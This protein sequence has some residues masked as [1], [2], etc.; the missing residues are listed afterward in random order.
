MDEPR[1]L[2]DDEQQVWRRL[3]GVVLTLPAALEQ[4][5]QR[6]AGI[7]H[8]EYWVMA[9]LS[10]APE[11]RMKLSQ[12]AAMANASLSRLS[13]VMTRLQRRGWVSRAPCPE[14]AR[15]TYGVLTDAGW[16]KVVATA[17]GHVERVRSIVFD[18]LDRATA[19]ELARACDAILGRMHTA[20]RTGAED[21]AGS[22]AS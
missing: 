19:A 14:D 8:F 20:G 2:D 18:G 17:P 1:W 9:L 13:H 22:L 11:R 6:D 15:A 3:I 7:S 10:E 16:D 4:Q 21:A 5:L 12:L